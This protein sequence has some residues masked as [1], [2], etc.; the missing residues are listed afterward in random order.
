MA[1]K[2][3]DPVREALAGSQSLVGC[4]DWCSWAEAYPK[5]EHSTTS[6]AELVVCET[7][8]VGNDTH[9]LTVLEVRHAAA[10]PSKGN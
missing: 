9:H 2:T 10:P 7:Y 1:G 5:H 4:P 8:D 3:T 6:G